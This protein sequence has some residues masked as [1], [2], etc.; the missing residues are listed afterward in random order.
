[1]LKRE[2]AALRLED[3]PLEVVRKYDELCVN[4]CAE[5]GYWF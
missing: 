4:F 2:S 5:N 3:M 1:M